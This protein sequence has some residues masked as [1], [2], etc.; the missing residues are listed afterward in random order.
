MAPKQEMSR[1]TAKDGKTQNNAT[2]MG[3]PGTP[4]QGHTR[5]AQEKI[6]F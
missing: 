3:M 4:T 6:I 2:G 1:S 5:P